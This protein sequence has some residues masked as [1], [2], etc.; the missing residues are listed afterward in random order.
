MST[1]NRGYLSKG[2][3][4]YRSSTRQV[5]KKDLLAYFMFGNTGKKQGSGILQ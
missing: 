5:N 3:N 1:P 2:S 4:V